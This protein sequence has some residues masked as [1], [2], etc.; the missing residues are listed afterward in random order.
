MKYY[1]TSVYKTLNVDEAFESIIESGL[2]NK[3]YLAANQPKTSVNGSLPLG[4]SYSQEDSKE[5]PLTGE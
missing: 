4:H 3:R 5:N 1:T 2:K